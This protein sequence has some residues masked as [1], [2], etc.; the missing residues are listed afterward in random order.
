MKKMFVLI[1]MDSDQTGFR[2]SSNLELMKKKFEEAKQE[3]LYDRITLAEVEEDAEIGFGVCGDFYGGEVIRDWN[4]SYEDDDDDFIDP[5][6]GRGL[7]S[8]I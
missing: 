1:M 4:F 7:H 8:H 3:E 6:G 5:A 2:L